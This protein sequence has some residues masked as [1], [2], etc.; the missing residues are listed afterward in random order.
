MKSVMTMVQ[1]W[2]KRQTKYCSFMRYAARPLEMIQNLGLDWV[3]AIPYG[4]GKLSG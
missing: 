3:K 1:E 4:S 2:T